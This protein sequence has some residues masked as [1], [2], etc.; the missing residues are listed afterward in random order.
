[1]RALPSLLLN[2]AHKKDMA[3][4]IRRMSSSGLFS[5]KSIDKIQSKKFSNNS[6]LSRGMSGNLMVKDPE[7]LQIVD[8]KSI[9]KHGS[10]IRVIPLKK[11]S[12]RKVFEYGSKFEDSSS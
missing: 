1:M 2:I 5:F 4:L 6:I 7:R 10:T 8:K 3:K 11:L 12:S 9:L